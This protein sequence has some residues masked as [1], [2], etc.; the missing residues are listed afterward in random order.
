MNKKFNRENFLIKNKS[1]TEW[2]LLLSNWDLF[3]ITRPVTFDKIRYGDLYRPDML[4]YRV[5]NDESYWWVLCKVN[6]ID[7]IWNDMYNGMEIII[8]DINDI[9]D[10]YYV[11]RRRR[12][13]NK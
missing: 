1:N 13:H 12:K 9:E 4:S 6:Q 7:D 5:Y 8:P 2:D 11:V 10:F 3:K